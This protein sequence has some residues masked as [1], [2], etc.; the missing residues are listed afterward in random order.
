MTNKEAIEKYSIEDATHLLAQKHCIGQRC[1]Y[2]SMKCIPL[3][4]VL[5]SGKQK[6][7]VFGERNWKEKEHI[8]KIR[9]V[10]PMDLRRITPN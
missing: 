8:K 6:A 2:Y 1:K 3:G 4:E 10:W 5:F 7:L 9:Y